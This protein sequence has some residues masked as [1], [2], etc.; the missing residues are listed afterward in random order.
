MNIALVGGG[1]AAVILLDFFAMQKDIKV[2]GISDI[3]ESAP[4]MKHAKALG[5]QTTTNTKELAQRHD[6]QTIIE[7]TG[8]ANV[9]SELL[10]ILRPNQDFMSANCAKLTSDIIEAQSTHNAMTAN[11]VSEQFHTSITRLNTAIGNM[12]F[13]YNNIEKLLRE[14]ELVALNAK[15]EC[16]RAGQAGDAF[17]K[18]VERMHEMLTSIREAMEKISTASTESHDTLMKLKSAKDQLADEFKLS[19]VMGAINK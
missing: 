13:A 4:G 18:V 7:L 2:V 14:T 3:N 17:A 15:I 19:K 12:D 5:I 10:G 11:T 8:N 16:A 9:R 6:V 1:R